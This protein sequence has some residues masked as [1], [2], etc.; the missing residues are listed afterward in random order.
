VRQHSDIPSAGQAPGFS[1]PVSPSSTSRQSTT[2]APTTAA[3]ATVRL[4]FLGDDYTAGSGAS[5]RNA[6]WTARVSAA[7]DVTATTVSADGAGYATAGAGGKSYQDLVD[8]VAA[9]KPQIVV[10][11]G[12]RNDVTQ[13][14]AQVR[15][16]AQKV[17]ANLHTLLPDAKLVAIAP[18]WGDSPHP[19]KLTKVDTAV[20][21]AVEAVHGV[22][23][24]IADAL[25]GHPTWMADLA[26]PNDRG[27]RAIATSVTGPLQAQLPH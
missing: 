15:I 18:W 22:Y 25:R 1:E 26:D 17:F 20:Q 2:T 6:G 23:L 8:E 19:R 24:D 21:T 27:Y 3:P 7:L 11:S 4:A 5:S 10:V 16:A 14:P 13:T 9:A 12:G